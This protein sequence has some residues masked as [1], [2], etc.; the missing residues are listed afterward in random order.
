VRG[1]VTAQLAL[2]SLRHRPLRT[3]LTALGIAIAIAST[4]VFM[5]IGE[6]LRKAFADQLAGLG[7]D[8]QVSFGEVGDDLFPTAPDLPAEYVERLRADAER[9]GIRSVTPALL[10]LRGGLSPSQSFVFEG[11]PTDVPLNEV[12]TGASVVEGRLLTPEDEEALVAVVGRSVASRARLEV[13]DEL[14]LNPDATFEVVGVVSSDA[15][16]L[17]NLVIVPFASLREA[18]GVEDR[19]STIMVKLEDP[20]RADRVAEEIEVAYP[21][22]GAQTQAGA[23]S[24]VQ[25]S[26][27]ISDFVRLGIS[28]IALVV[29]AIAVAN[30]MMMSVFERTR[31]FGVV[32]AVGARP[33]FLFSIVVLE[34][35]VLS[36]VGAAVGVGLGTLATRVVNAIA[37]DYVGLSVAAVTPRLVAFAV[38]VAAATGLLAGLLPA[39]RAA[40]V[41]IAVAVA[42]E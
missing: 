13:G 27:R 35:V 31:E 11:L 14:R 25:D 42:R 7:P 2:A 41:P 6:G 24:V 23:M 19:V 21:D 8:I 18:M 20:A 32:R 39:G 5:S 28:A 26:L 15:G 1:A 29:G 3:G 12:F 36:L 30:T 33:T 37:N 17:E 16:L 9:F 38:L 4:V 40:R 22:L 34:S 10:Y